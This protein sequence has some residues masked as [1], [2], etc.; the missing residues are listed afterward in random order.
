MTKKSMLTRTESNMVKMAGKSATTPRNSMSEA[1]VSSRNFRRRSCRHTSR[2]SPGSSNI[3]TMAVLR[4]IGTILIIMHRLQAIFW[5]ATCWKL[6]SRKVNQRSPLSSSWRSF[7]FRV[8]MP[9]QSA[10]GSFINLTVRSSTF[11][12]VTFVLMSTVPDTLGWVS[13]CYPSLTVKDSRR[14]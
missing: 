2:D 14:P 5:V 10:I 6:N 9:F 12:Q 13:I 3:T 7:Q 1:K 8:P 4:G 11:T